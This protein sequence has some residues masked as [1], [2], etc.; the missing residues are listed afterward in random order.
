M[1]PVGS[2]FYAAYG[3]GIAPV[4][5]MIRSPDPDIAA[6]IG[7]LGLPLGPSGRLLPLSHWSARIASALTLP[8]PTAPALVADMNSWVLEL[9]SLRDLS[10]ATATLFCQIAALGVLPDTT[11]RPTAE[12]HDLT[13]P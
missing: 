4:Y 1:F 10:P 5:R 6:D 2:P 7:T 9:S 11:L 3:R 8:D 13:C 12:R